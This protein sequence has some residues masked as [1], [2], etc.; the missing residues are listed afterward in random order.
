MLI[1]VRSMNLFIWHSYHDEYEDWYCLD[2]SL[3]FSLLKGYLE[4]KKTLLELMRNA[5]LLMVNRFYEDY[6]FFIKT[7]IVPIEDRYIFPGKKS[8]FSGR[9]PDTNLSI[10]NYIEQ[11]I[12]YSKKS[13][14]YVHPSIKYMNLNEDKISYLSL[15][16]DKKAA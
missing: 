5:P 6:N 12:V 9:F 16:S 4:N 8:Y 1:D 11:N 2:Y 7:D 15:D 3:N 13:V 14:N 10:T